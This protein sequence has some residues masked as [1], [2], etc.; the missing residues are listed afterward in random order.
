MD[1]YSKESSISVLEKENILKNRVAEIIEEHSI[2]VDTI[3]KNNELG[4]ENAQVN[5]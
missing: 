4:I 2:T 5:N 1:N 3:N